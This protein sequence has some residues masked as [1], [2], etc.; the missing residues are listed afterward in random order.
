M[1]ALDPVLPSEL[2]LRR[3][4]GWISYRDAATKNMARSEEAYGEQRQTRP[5]IRLRSEVHRISEA[6]PEAE[7]WRIV[8]S[9]CGQ[10]RR[11]ASPLHKTTIPPALIGLC[12]NCLDK[13]H[14]KKDCRERTRCWLC[15]RQGHRCFEC[16]RPSDL[17]RPA[18]KAL[19]DDRRPRHYA[20][21]APHQQLTGAGIRQDPMHQ[22]F[23]CSWT[24]LDGALAIISD[25]AAGVAVGDDDRTMEMTPLRK[26]RTVR[27]RHLH[28]HR[29]GGQRHRRHATLIVK[30]T[31]TNGRLSMNT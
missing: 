2:P 11:L 10:R 6:A 26:N 16:R 29:R 31:Q 25:A 9:R 1:R 15:S 20:K 22:M 13:R 30:L 5:R 3:E 8:R 28:H 4:S 17:R 18:P 21:E 19:T 12:F 23:S 7:G 27:L 14:R 24:Q